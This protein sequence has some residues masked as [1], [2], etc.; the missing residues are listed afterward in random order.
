M[1]L[2]NS[3]F[4]NLTSLSIRNDLKSTGSFLS[5]SLERMSS[6]LKINSA[7]DDASGCV[8]SSKTSIKINN[9]Y[10]VQNNIQRGASLLNIAQGAY[11]NMSNILMRLRSLS[12]QAMNDSYDDASRKAFEDEAI[13]L[14]NQLEQIRTSTNYN[15][16]S[17]F[18]N[19]NVVGETSISNLATPEATNFSTRAYFNPENFALTTNSTSPE[20]KI[21]EDDSG[22][23]IFEYD[24]GGNSDGQLN[25]NQNQEVKETNLALSY[26][27]EPIID[28]ENQS[29]DIDLINLD[30]QDNNIQTE[31]PMMMSMAR[32]VTPVEETTIEVKDWNGVQ[33]QIG[34][35]VYKVKNGNSSAGSGSLT[36]SMDE[37]GKVT[38]VAN[39]KDLYIYATSNEKNNLHIIRKSRMN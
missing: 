27:N 13:E 21:N 33:I 35:T 22:G 12:V 1:P 2:N 39:T 38:L 29:E 9:L 3:I 11:Q 37:N 26:S 17:L 25:I 20:T 32:S 19:S 7:K 36:Y 10:Q 24:S 15:G 23:G 4:T 34:D 6:G 8:I 18:D 16:I 14:T 30:E 31:Q 28:N 5:Q